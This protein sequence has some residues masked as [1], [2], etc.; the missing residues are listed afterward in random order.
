MST[1]H[2]QH[3][4]HSWTVRDTSHIRNVAYLLTHLLVKCDCGFYGWV[5]PA[6]TEH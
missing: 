4:S 1:W 6:D 5:T 2:R 3:G